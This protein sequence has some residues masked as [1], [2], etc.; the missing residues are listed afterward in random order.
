MGCL[1]D[2]GSQLRRNY[3]TDTVIYVTSSFR[4]LKPLSAK[5]LEANCSYMNFLVLVSLR[6][7]LLKV[8]WWL[9]YLIIIQ[10][11]LDSFK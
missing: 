9:E 4:T 3:G 7:L 6:Y 5:I 11:V 10:E 8:V 1:E 2:T